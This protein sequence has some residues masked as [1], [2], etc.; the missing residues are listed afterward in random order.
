MLRYLR[1]T[2]INPLQVN[3]SIFMNNTCISHNL[4]GRVALCNILANLCKDLTNYNWILVSASA[5]T[6]MYCLVLGE[7][8]EENELHRDQQ[9]EKGQEF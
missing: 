6:L 9:L 5:F 2:I 3:I 7:V 1:I 4:V 8:N